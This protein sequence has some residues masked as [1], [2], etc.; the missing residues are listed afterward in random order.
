MEITD[1]DFLESIKD[2]LEKHEWDYV[3]KNINKVELVRNQS[4]ARSRK[5]YE[6]IS[7]NK[8][9]LCITCDR[10]YTTKQGLQKHKQSKIHEKNINKK[11]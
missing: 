5:Y 3:R 4:N 11:N 7:K 9:H 10:F 2:R 6:S 1:R 8:K